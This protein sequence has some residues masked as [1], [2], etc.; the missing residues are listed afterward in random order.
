M[1][2]GLLFNYAD[3]VLHITAVS[4]KRVSGRWYD[5]S[6]NLREFDTLK[7]ILEYGRNRATC[8]SYL[9]RV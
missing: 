8:P 9:Q 4:E 5:Q 2:P 7:S 6:L 3:D 1:G